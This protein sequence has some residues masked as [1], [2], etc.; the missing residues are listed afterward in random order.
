MSA[1]ISAAGDARVVGIDAPS[2]SF[3]RA[4]AREIREAAPGIDALG[5]LATHT[6][7]VT[8]HA[9]R[10][11]VAATPLPV[12][13]ERPVDAYEHDCE[14]AEP[15]AVQ[16]DHEAA[17]LARSRSL[18]GALEAPVA[19]RLVDEARETAMA[20]RLAALGR[21]GD[22]VAVVGFDHLDDVAG[23]LE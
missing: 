18:L 23:Q 7:G 11:R 5:D 20:N 2:G 3:A 19:A 15:P 12:P 22:V 4:L 10:C 21:E 13:A 8:G 6:L 9:L 17:S 1:A 16:A 14:A